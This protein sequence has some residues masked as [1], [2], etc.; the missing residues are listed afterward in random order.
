MT[1]HVELAYARTVTGAQGRNVEGGV[2]FY[3]KPTDVRNLYVAMT[4]GT[5]MNE[6]FI[7]TSGEQTAVDVFAQ[8]IATDWIDLPAH[9]RRAELRDERPH[10]PGL[11]DGREFRELLEQRYE[12]VSTIEHAEKTLQRLP[13]ERQQ[14]ERAKA[15]D[16]KAITDRAAAYGAA[17]DVLANYDR[18]LHRRKHATE[19]TA[20][21]L[22]TERLPSG[23]KAAENELSVAGSK[24][25]GLRQE[26]VQAKADLRRR[27]DLETKIDEIDDRLDHDLRIR[28][29][30]TRLEPPDTIVNTIGDRPAPGPAAPQW[31]TAAG[32]LAQHQAAFEI[33]DGVG[34]LPRAL[35]RNAYIESRADV[36]DLILP[37]VQPPPARRLRI[38]SG[39]I[40]L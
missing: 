16:E 37:L 6:A 17:E 28:T 27:P 30:I 35:E 4:R 19:I 36:Q 26:Q 15:T 21:R 5:A 34:R 2:S 14:A 38:E 9:A 12:I 11:L 31:D 33:T 40:E 32:R 25:D 23:V 13:G 18:P 3:N 29:R 20:A 22:D 8:S 10:C 24:L 7:V 1:E 39:G